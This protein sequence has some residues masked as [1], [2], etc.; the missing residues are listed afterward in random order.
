MKVTGTDRPGNAVVLSKG[1]TDLYRGK[2]PCRVGILST[3]LFRG[4]IR[5]SGGF[6][7]KSNKGRREGEK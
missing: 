6:L 7:R 5:I 4:N 3:W 1:R 2:L